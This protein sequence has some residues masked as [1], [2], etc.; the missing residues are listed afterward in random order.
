MA[1]SVRELD[2]KVITFVVLVFIGLLITTVSAS[3]AWFRNE[4]RNQQEAQ[5]RP[6][7][8]LV[9]SD[10][11][12]LLDLAGRGVRNPEAEPAEQRGSHVNIHQAMR[13]VV[14]EN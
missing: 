6:S 14:A 10:R 12:Q 5:W 4:V 2:F 1:A 3:V 9:T 7:I 11:D 13:A 8:D